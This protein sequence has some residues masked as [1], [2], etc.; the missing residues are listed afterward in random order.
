[1]KERAGSENGARI[2]AEVQ[3][4][5]SHLVIVANIARPGWPLRGWTLPS[6]IRTPRVERI[7]EGGEGG[8]DI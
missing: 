1:M 4:E 8:G 5:C 7:G 3:G 6:F 2:H